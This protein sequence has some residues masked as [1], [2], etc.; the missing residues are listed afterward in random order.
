MSVRGSN[1]DL[2]SQVKYYLEIEEKARVRWKKE[3][4]LLD[5]LPMVSPT[6]RLVANAN[7]GREDAKAQAFG[8]PNG[9]LAVDAGAAGGNRQPAAMEEKKKAE[10]TKPKEPAKGFDK[11][12]DD[13][14]SKRD[15]ARQPDK[16]PPL[17]S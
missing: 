7:A 4:A 17:P 6:V 5:L 11:K 8:K 10:P 9:R 12:W 14:W 2:R 3:M 16:L 15:F 13:Y 1:Q